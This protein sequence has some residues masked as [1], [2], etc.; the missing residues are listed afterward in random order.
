MFEQLIFEFKK[1]CKQFLLDK[2]IKTFGSL[3][4][5]ALDIPHILAVGISIESVFL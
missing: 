4:F 1:H 3:L 5:L 2:G